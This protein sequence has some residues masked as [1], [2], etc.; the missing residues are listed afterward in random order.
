[1]GGLNN[2]PKNSSVRSV[3]SSKRDK[4]LHILPPLYS[5]SEVLVARYSTVKPKLDLT[6]NCYDDLMENG[7]G[8]ARM[9]VKEETC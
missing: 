3:Q 6:V 1:M 8:E 2:Q 5:Y 4:N 9:Q 7:D